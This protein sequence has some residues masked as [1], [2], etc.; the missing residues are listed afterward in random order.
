LKKAY[1]ERK[2]EKRGGKQPRAASGGKKIGREP[3]PVKET[4]FLPARVESSRVREGLTQGK[5]CE[6]KKGWA[7]AKDSLGW[8]I[9]KKKKDGLPVVNHRV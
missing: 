8:G 4:H 7:V 5:D 3:L 2:S 1:K 6:R 9:I